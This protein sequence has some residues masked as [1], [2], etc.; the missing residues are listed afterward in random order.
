MDRIDWIITG[1]VSSIMITCFCLG[2]QWSYF[3]AG[4]CATCIFVVN[5][6]R[7]AQ[8]AETKR[9]HD[10]WGNFIEKLDTNTPVSAE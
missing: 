5:I 9:Q 3:C 4:I 1:I 8:L 6:G 10:E 2:T 7:L